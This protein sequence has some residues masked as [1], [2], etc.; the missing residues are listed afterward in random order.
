MRTLSIILCGLWA[1]A[2]MHSQVPKEPKTFNGTQVK[3]NSE[4]PYFYLDENGVTIKCSN[5]QPGDT[6]TVNDITYEAVDRELLEQRK[7]EGKDLSTV[8]TSLITDMSQLF[9]ED[10]SFNQDIGSWDVSSVTNMAAMFYDATSFNQ[11]IGDWDVGNVTGMG[12]MFYDATSFNQDLSNWCVEN[13]TS[14]PENFASDICPLQPDFYPEWG[15]C[16][17][18]EPAW[19]QMTS[20]K[21]ATGA[22]ISCV[23]DSLIYIIGGQDAVP[24][25]L[26]TTV[27]YNT[28][29]DKWSDL[30]P[31]PDHC[32]GQSAGVINDKIYF[33]TEWKKGNSKWEPSDSTFAYDPAED[34][35]E[36]KERCPKKGGGHASCALNN[37]LYLLG[38]S[39]DALIGDISRQN[40]AL[41]YDPETN[42]WDSIPDMLYERSFHNA[43][44]YENQIYVFGGKVHYMNTDN[45]LVQRIVE[46]TEKYDP[47]DS[48]WTELADLP[49]P[50]AASI[51]VEYDDKLYVFGGVSSHSI[52]YAPC[53]NFIQEYNPSTNEW[54]LMHPMPF[55][56]AVM[57]GQKVDKFVYLIGGYQGNARAFSLVLD[58]VWR[59]NLDSLRPFTY[60]TDVS[61]DNES[62]ELTVDET[63]QLVATV[64]P[65]NASDPSI[66]WNSA[67][68]GIASVGRDGIVEGKAVGMT[69]IYVTTSDGQFKDSCHVEVTPGVGI[70]KA[71]T[72]QLLI[73]PNPTN[74]LITI[75]GGLPGTKI[76]EISSLS[77]KLILSIELR[78][79]TQQLDLSSFQKGV[80]FITIR[81][82][83]FV[84]ARKIIKL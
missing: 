44:V 5:C 18:I 39:K 33:K 42:T 79:T 37:K 25:S 36:S 73:F 30:A 3:S 75:Q 9:Y 55:N 45:N 22:S 23:M 12:W 31:A 8:C 54:R 16:S 4:D 71:E 47:I 74:N 27:V 82:K 83:D 63:W 65:Q 72:D 48:T 78:G 52:S 50:V 49:V 40:E 13:I 29:T 19:K 68:P 2:L 60:V 51:T 6:G 34:S 62:L 53:T 43:I 21:V 14:K 69:E 76:I 26:N 81:S 56:R 32:T 64:L 11:D 59:F 58:E 35:W 70:V 24:M 80:Y 77:G 20:M 10:T 57:V 1:F 66:S 17:T 84:T 7:N 67:D 41:V 38:N 28:K 15:T 61:L 46:K